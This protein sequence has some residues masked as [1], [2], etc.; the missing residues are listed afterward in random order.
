MSQ[1]QFN[2]LNKIH[3]MTWLPILWDISQDYFAF[4]QWLCSFHA[5]ICCC[6]HNVYL[7]GMW[8]SYHVPNETENAGFVKELPTG[9]PLTAVNCENTSSRSKGKIQL[10]K[11]LLWI[12]IFQAD[13]SGTTFSSR[14]S[15]KYHTS[16]WKV[17][18]EV[19]W[20]SWKSLFCSLPFH[21]QQLVTAGSS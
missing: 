11:S 7:R 6:S 17:Q 12:Y 21:L 1:N 4:A 9:R 20:E 10:V 19:V 18:T 2:F 14:V 16:A 5:A 3:K 8:R 13:L 15:G